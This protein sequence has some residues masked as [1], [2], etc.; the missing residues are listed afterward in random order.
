LIAGVNA[1]LMSRMS[2]EMFPPAP[3]PVPVPPPRPPAV[4]PQLPIPERPLGW[5][6]ALLVCVIFYSISST[7]V[8]ARSVAEYA[9]W[10]FDGTVEAMIDMLCAWPLTLWLACVIAP[11]N[12]REA[13]PFRGFSKSLIAPLMLCGVGMSLVLIE[14]TGWIPTPEWIEQIFRELMSGHP[15]AKFVAL[16]VIPPIA[17]EMLFRGLIFHEFARRYSTRHA[18]FGSAALFALFHLNPWQAVVAFPIGVLAAWLALRTGSI[19][20]GMV[21][22]AALNFTSSFLIVPVGSLLGYTEDQIYELPHLP[23]QMVLAG[24][25]VATIGLAWLWMWARRE[26]GK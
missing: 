16:V 11:A 21:L 15:A 5:G 14:V 20:P 6:K 24:G 9:G 19:I 26:R 2:Q 8:L 10:K 18:I 25:V 3:T 12:W 4:A 17:E 13:F 22:H 7:S 23:W 1:A